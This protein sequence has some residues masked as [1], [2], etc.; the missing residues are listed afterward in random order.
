M[1][2]R[3][4]SPW[5]AEIILIEV[6]RKHGLTIAD[7]R[8]RSRVAHLIEPRFEAYARLQDEMQWSLPRI[9]KFMNRDNHTSIMHGIRE[10]KKWRAAA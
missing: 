3:R 2:G 5:E 7:L 8:S 6:A 4:K 9:A 1:S 10:F